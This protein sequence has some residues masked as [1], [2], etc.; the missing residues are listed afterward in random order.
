MHM[1]VLSVGGK[2]YVKASV[3]ARDLGYTADY[4]GQLCRSRKVNAKLVGRSW[5]VDRNSIHLHKTNRYR[6]TQAKTKESLRE[7]IEV[8]HTPD[9]GFKIPLHISQGEKV[10][11]KKPSYASYSDDPADLI[12]VISKT[13]SQNLEVKLADAQPVSISSK[14]NE[15]I[16]ETPKLP[17][18]KFKGSIPVTGLEDEDSSSDG[19]GSQKVVHPRWI[20]NLKN[21][22]KN[23]D[24][25]SVSVHVVHESLSDDMLTK[26]SVTLEANKDE[27]SGSLEFVQEQ[28]FSVSKIALFATTMFSFALVLMLFGLESNVSVVGQDL[29]SSYSFAL[30]NL[31]ASAY[32]SIENFQ[33]VFYLVEFSTNLF[34]F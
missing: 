26:E 7:E 1:E 34:F 12:P 19:E 14:G 27:A 30:E 15:F 6:S 21:K 29:S 16:F 25:S 10:L 5:Y 20:S 3:I 17:E 9:R 4:V 18:I 28:T 13:S 31:S 8:V 11:V 22:S 2:D 23:I 24:I 33:S 32:T